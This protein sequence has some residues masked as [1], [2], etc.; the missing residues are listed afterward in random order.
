MI[1]SLPDDIPAWVF[2]D[3]QA[4]QPGVTVATIIQQLQ[5]GLPYDCIKCGGDGRYKPTASND[6]LKVTCELCGGIGKTLK[7]YEAQTTGTV[8]VEVTQQS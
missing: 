8:Y 5:E 6:N 7:Q 2:I 1:Y 3:A 4:Q